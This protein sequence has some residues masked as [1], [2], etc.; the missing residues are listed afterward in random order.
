MTVKPVPVYVFSVAAL[1]GVVAANNFIS[2][3]NPVGSG[4]AVSVGAV[5]I[6]NVALN[7]TSSVDPMRGFRI[8]SASGGTLVASSDIAKFV[9]TY[10]TP[11]AEVRTD[12]PTVSLGP[13]LFNSPPIITTG[14]GGSAVHDVLVPP[15][16]GP[17][18][19][20]PGEGLVVR[21]AGGDVDQRWNISVVWGE[22][23]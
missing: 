2:L 1:A 23:R 10:P 16:S 15:G 4:V 8:T 7:A 20:L 12:N 14:T 22:R 11:A 3:M 6:S 17:F 9:S 5:F 21:T 13:S 19:L 18:L